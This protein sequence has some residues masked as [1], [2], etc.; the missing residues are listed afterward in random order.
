MFTC[1]DIW[2]TIEEI[3]ELMQRSDGSGNVSPSVQ[4]LRRPESDVE[5][6]SDD[7]RA[8]VYQW[9]THSTYIQ[10][11]PYFEDFSNADVGEMEDVH[12]ARPLAI[13][14][15]SVTTD[16]ISPAGAIKATSPGRSCTC[17]RSALMC[18][19]S[20]ATARG[21]AITR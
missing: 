14:G 16:H 8:N 12:G 6:D 7:E 21:A 9:D 1:S 2:P 13:F 17:S 11:P 5:R 3:S 4:R 10:E 20:T 19:T 15:D 18:K